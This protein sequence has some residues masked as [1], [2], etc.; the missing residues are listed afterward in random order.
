MNC[1]IPLLSLAMGGA[2]EAAR[3]MS[4]ADSA[5]VESMVEEL[6][7]EVSASTEPVGGADDDGRT[8]LH[9]LG[10]LREPGD[11]LRRPRHDP[12]GP[13]HD[14]GRRCGDGL[15]LIEFN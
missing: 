13:L 3:T 1:Q 11:G 9:P 5:A 14:R 2:Q 7:D 8:L 10:D 4:N 12:R 15:P 6:V